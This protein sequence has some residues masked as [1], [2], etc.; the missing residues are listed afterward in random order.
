V[1]KPPHQGH[2]N[3]RQRGTSESQAHS[4][5]E[6]ERGAAQ[7][8]V[9]TAASRARRRSEQQW[10][11]LEVT[12][13]RRTPHA[14]RDTYYVSRTSRR[15]GGSWVTVQGER[16]ALLSRRDA[17]LSMNSRK[18][19]SLEGNITS[20]LSSRLPGN[21]GWFSAFHT[22]NAYD[23]APAAATASVGRCS[24]VLARRGPCPCRPRGSPLL[25]WGSRQPGFRRV[26]ERLGRVLP[27]RGRDEGGRRRAGAD[28]ARRAQRLARTVC[29]AAQGVHETD[30]L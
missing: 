12:V 30:R 21:S 10:R 25:N 9:S 20:V 1:G 18:S 19:G 6:H 22:V 5:T 28:L 14:V 13:I 29:R 2:E 16:P 3:A 17:Y 15:R 27:L 8:R 11:V 23:H 4:R 24:Q 26:V 7:T